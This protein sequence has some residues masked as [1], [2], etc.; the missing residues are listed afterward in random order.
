[1]ADGH[2]PTLVSATRDAN[3]TTNPM[4]VRLTDGTD[5][6]LIDGSGNL[7]VVVNNGAGAS[8]VNIQD[9]G[10]S[11]TVDGSVSITGSV[12]VTATDLDIRDLTHVSDSVKIGDGTDFLAV[13]ADGSINVVATLT[14]DTLDDDSAFTVGTSKVYPMGAL[15]DETSPDSVNEGDI[16]AP[17][18]TLDRK[19]L[20]R[21]VG[22]TDANRMEIDASGRPTVNVNGTVPVSATDLDIRDLT[23]VSDSVKIGDGTDFLAID[24]SGN[25]GVTDAGGSLTVDGTVTVTATDL[26]I[27]DL[28]L[29]QDSVKISANTSANSA[30]NPIYVKEVESILSSTEVHNYDTQSALAA[31]STDN[32]DYTVTGTTFLLKSIIFSCSGAGK[33]ELQTGPVASL[34]TRA[35]A[36]VPTRGGHAQLE[37]NPPIEV[38]ATSTGTV[39]LI[40]TNRENQAQDVY[41]TIIGND[42]P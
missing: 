30:T 23:H 18:M 12:T 32:H 40:R 2:F 31:D 36:F 6:S 22:S 1:M 26:D 11:I 17:R 24:G 38:P 28:T 15:A 10:N 4:F 27:R 14:N 21:V 20:I 42:I 39:R 35:V 8:A 41:S 29:A 13:N 7:N 34:V 5:A 25:I 16:G 33:V 3:S 37:F 9:G 19:L